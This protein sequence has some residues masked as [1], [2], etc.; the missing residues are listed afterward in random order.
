[1]AHPKS[2][3]NADRPGMF[4]S[5]QEAVKVVAMWVA[6]TITPWAILLWIIL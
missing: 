3:S 1:M 6:I 4:R 5:W 2:P